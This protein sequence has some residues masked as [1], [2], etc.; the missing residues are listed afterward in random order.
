MP[1]LVHDTRPEEVVTHEPIVPEATFDPHDLLDPNDPHA[2]NCGLC[3]AN[4]VPCEGVID[5][6]EV[7]IVAQRL[8]IDLP[9]EIRFRIPWAYM[10]SAGTC[11][12]AHSNGLGK[13][14]LNV[15]PTL[16]LAKAN[17][18]VL[19]EMTHAAQAERYTEAQWAAVK[20][21][22][23]YA[24]RDPQGYTFHPIEVEARQVAHYLK[25]KHK[26]VVR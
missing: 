23:P 4:R 20:G 18:I 13:H 26:V 24:E 5:R 25:D 16:A 3:D 19:H 22:C 6:A 10:G 15:D 2:C 14:I 12:D 21:S 7:G 9:V 17:E 1:T 8:G 11:Y